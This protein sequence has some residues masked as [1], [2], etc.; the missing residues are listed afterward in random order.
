MSAFDFKPRGS[1][2]IIFGMGRLGTV[3]DIARSVAFL[4]GD[5]SAY[6]TGQ[7]LGVNGGME[8]LNMQMPRAWGGVG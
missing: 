2:I 3:D 5:E 8:R 1:E 7:V 4:L 6:V